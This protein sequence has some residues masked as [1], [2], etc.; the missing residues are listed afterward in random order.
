MLRSEITY[1]IME[2]I[3]QG[4]IVDDEKLDSR[5]VEQFIRSK[6]AEYVQT[7]VDSNKTLGES[8]YQYILISGKTQVSKQNDI[9]KVYRLAEVPKLMFSRYGVII[10]EL[11]GNTNLLE[12]DYDGGYHNT[13]LFDAIID[14]GIPSTINFDSYTNSDTIEDTI[15]SLPFKV[16]N[17]SHF[18]VSG[19]GRFNR[20][21]IF[22]T[23]KND[24]IYVKSK[25]LVLPD[26]NSFM[27]KTVLE[28]P[29][30]SYG[31][32]PYI[33]DYPITIQAFE[34]I[35]NQVLTVD[36]KIFLSTESDV[37]NDASGEINK[38]V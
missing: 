4:S 32:D 11:N 20:N 38:T 8:F 37:S 16:V 29:E 21:Y 33:N 17:N 35:K 28:K 7:I 1:A 5:L 23:Y 6:R 3:R 13:V 14:G 10:A 19:E 18:K 15:V 9:D 12:V 36:M 30:D 22:T 31:F 34:Y 25:G 27:I 24:N 26:I 2:L